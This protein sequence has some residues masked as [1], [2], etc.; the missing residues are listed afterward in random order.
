MI[1]RTDP[2]EDK[3]ACL[4]GCPKCSFDPRKGRVSPIEHAEGAKYI[5]AVRCW[6]C[7]TFIAWM[8]E[9]YILDDGYGGWWQ[10]MEIVVEEEATE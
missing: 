1:H 10:G 7:N 4:P 5:L 8:H 9:Q 3:R 6:H 2:T